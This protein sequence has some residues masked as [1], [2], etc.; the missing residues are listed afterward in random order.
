M[1]PVEPFWLREIV[2]VNAALA[3]LMMGTKKV[4]GMKP[5][6]PAIKPESESWP[7]TT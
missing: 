7:A 1:A 3:I 5:E 2:G 6:P 4:T